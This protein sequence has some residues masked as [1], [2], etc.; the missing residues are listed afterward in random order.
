MVLPEYSILV[1]DPEGRQLNLRNYFPLISGGQEW[2]NE[3]TTWIRYGAFVQHR[4]EPQLREL[5]MKIVTE[6][7]KIRDPRPFVQAFCIV[8]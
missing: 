7:G 6:D 8:L 5:R 3:N 1:W 4:V 2:N